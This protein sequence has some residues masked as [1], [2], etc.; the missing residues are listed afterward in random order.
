MSLQIGDRVKVFTQVGLMKTG[1]WLTGK[2]LD[3]VP[4]GSS[5]VE[6]SGNKVMCDRH[7]VRKYVRLERDQYG[8]I[9]STFWDKTWE[10]L[11]RAVTLGFNNPTVLHHAYA[12]DIDEDEKMI[13]IENGWISVSPSTVE[14]E[15]IISFIEAPCWAISI[16]TTGCQTYWEP[17]DVDVNEVAYSENPINAAQL[18]VKTVWEESNRPFW[19]SMSPEF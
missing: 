5:M 3:D 9:L 13:S 17:A 19:D 6:V 7:K 4:D 12:L 15:S 11:K 14:K 18:F 8:Q 2:Y 16:A 1:R 10:E